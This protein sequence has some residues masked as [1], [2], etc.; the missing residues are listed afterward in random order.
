MMKVK[1][2]RR[3]AEKRKAELQGKEEEAK[4]ANHENVR[5]FGVRRVEA[6]R[7]DD[8][9]HEGKHSCGESAGSSVFGQ[10]VRASL[11]RQSAHGGIS[12]RDFCGQRF[13]HDTGKL[14]KNDGGKDFETS[15]GENSDDGEGERT[16]KSGDE[17]IPQRQGF[18]ECWRRFRVG[19]R[20]RPH[21]PR[22]RRRA[23]RDHHRVPGLEGQ[24]GGLCIQA[25]PGP[26]RRNSGARR[27][28]G[29]GMWSSA[30]P[31]AG[32][33]TQAHTY[34]GWSRRRS[35]RKSAAGTTRS[36]GWTTFGLRTRQRTEETVM[37]EDGEQETEVAGEGEYGDHFAGEEGELV[38]VRTAR[39]GIGQR[40]A[41]MITPSDGAWTR[42]GASMLGRPI[43][44]TRGITT[45]STTT[46]RKATAVTT[47]R[48]GIE[49][50][51]SVPLW[52]LM[53]IRRRERGVGISPYS[54]IFVTHWS[55]SSLVHL[56]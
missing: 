12:M 44:T 19:L 37:G 52:M 13:K 41:G 8:D 46:M 2:E 33:A 24:S 35:A 16:S 17:K 11:D 49:G 50:E 40:S 45:A 54:S 34:P 56:T 48:L 38:I 4:P 36:S 23:H 51:P 29:H 18:R 30:A 7:N 6:Q 43:A 21:R 32:C 1:V 10:G 39:A 53:G 3:K 22:R 9:V 31:A 42:R 15:S 55:V 20:R 27:A 5:L 47:K 25:W 26:G 14:F 28:V